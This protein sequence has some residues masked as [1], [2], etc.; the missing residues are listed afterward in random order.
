MRNRIITLSHG[1]GGKRSYDLLNQ[2]ILKYLDNPVLKKLEDSAVLNLE[3]GKIAFTTDS[4]VVKPLFFPGGDIGK[5]AVFGTVND[6]A[7]MGA[8]PLF[9][10]LSLII[11]EGLSIETL[12]KVMESIA[13][14]SQIAGVEIITGDTK[15][16]EKG[17]GDGLFINTSGLGVLLEGWDL[18]TGNLSGDEVIIING[19]I[20]DHGITIINAREEFGFSGNLQSDC[21]PLS[22]IVERLWQAGIHVRCMRDLTRG[23][24]GT[25]L[26]EISLASGLGM[27]VY[28]E[29][30]KLKSS[31]EYACE[32][33]GLD[34]LY[35]ANEGKMVVFVPQKEEKEALE[36]IRSHPFGKEAEV[37]GKVVNKHREVILFTRSGGKR[38]LDLAE[39]EIPRIC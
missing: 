33:L 5:L 29:K 4:F 24:L 26:K 1:G 17:S 14:A 30:I 23:G 7:V 22:P 8:K 20:G 36:I 15:V 13:E 27:E 16:V 19:T 10:S 2:I 11:E 34:P 31:V 38:L 9:L 12:E 39:E 28:E 3:R 21:A 18:S 32:V 35:L 25:I 6:L 37:I